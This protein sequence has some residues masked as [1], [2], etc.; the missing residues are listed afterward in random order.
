LSGLNLDGQPQ[1]NITP[2]KISV[3]LRASDRREKWWAGYSVRTETEVNRV[4]PLLLDSP[5]LIAQDLLG[6][7]GFS[8]HRIAGGY[9]WRSG[10]QRIGLTLSLDN[11]AN[12][13]YREQ[14]QFAPARGRSFSLQ[15]HI[16]G[17][18]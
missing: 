2:W 3:G 10:D 15:L 4:S 7:A 6:L 1:D 14:Y 8:V 5:F 18:K 12:R 17:V 9:D 13:F 16:R 11:L